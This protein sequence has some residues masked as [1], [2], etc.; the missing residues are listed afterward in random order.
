MTGQTISHF[1]ILEKLGGGG[2]GIVYKAEDTHL[3]RN[4][5][6]KF[7]PSEFTRDAEAKERFMHEAQAA[8]ALDHPNICNIHEIGE[9][10]D[11]QMFIAMACYEGDTLQLRIA[12]GQL[13]IEEAVDL[14]IQVGQGLQKAHEK[15][16]VHRDIKPANIIITNDGVGKILDFGLAKLAGQ[17]KLTRTG[18]TVGTAAYMSPEQAQG[19]EVDH[20]TDIWS[21]GVVLFEM[22]TGKLPFRGEHEAALLYSIVHEEPLTISGFRTDIP[23]NL[24][25]VI[26]KTL[27]KD[28]RQR[29]Q[30]ARELVSDLKAAMTPGI[31]LPKQEKSIVVLPFENLS[32]DPDNAFFADGLTEELIAD[33]SKVQALRVI[34]RTSAMMYKG[35]KKSVPVIAQELGVR[36]VLEGSVRRAGSS[37]RITAQLIDSA[38]D[39]HLW[40]EKYAGT[41][42]DVFALQEQMS[43]QIVGGLR[44][45]LTPDEDRRLAARPIQDVRAYD[46]WLR[47][48]QEVWTFSKEGFDR[49]FKLVNYALGIV[50]EN[51]LL[52]AGLGWFY[53]L[54]YDFGISHEQQ[55]LLSGERHA[56]RALELG[57]DL[58]QAHYAMAYVRYKQGDFAVAMREARR[59]IQ[60]ERA[61]EALWLLGFVLAEIG[62]IDEARRFADEAVASDP[63]NPFSTFARAA[64]DFFD[65][66][67]VEAASR[68]QDYLDKVSPGDLLLLW[69]L[70]QAQANAGRNEEAKRNF[71]Q[72]AKAEAVP[73]ADLSALF[74]RALEGDRN[75]VEEMLAANLRLQ[76]TAKT[77]EWFPNFIAACLAQVGDNNGALQW[78]ERAVGWGFSN[79]RFLNEHCRFLAPLRGDP[80]FR[81][82]IDRAREKERTFEI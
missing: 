41:L 53:A 11:G 7:L 4:V 79:H 21:L 68:F 78:L 60:E 52:Q 14:A 82:L 15:G 35:A 58:W 56:A 54:S 32:P 16:I 44:V 39:A 61:S 17:A 12:K 47:A 50:G 75:G 24:A 38:T 64:V 59:A 36:Y 28:P 57:P 62:R 66:R 73:I 71:E 65:G 2:M 20:R 6:L 10:E 27:Q 25:C 23:G 22:L 37:L 29:Y 5:A 74:C 67:F 80:R 48:G 69:W 81:D 3:R 19:L 31:Q 51:A 43:R 42:E 33:L 1:R 49:A 45:K 76:E 40:A 46:A 9:T 30:T 70:A 13:R 26:L 18:S 55:T 8:S 63:L 72:L 77:D 34:S